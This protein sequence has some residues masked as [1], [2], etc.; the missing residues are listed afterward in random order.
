MPKTVKRPKM[1]ITGQRV[2]YRTA[3]LPQPIAWRFARCLNKN[4]LFSDVKHHWD[5][6]GCYVRYR[7]STPMR[8]EEMLSRLQ[9]ERVVRAQEQG[10]SWIVRPHPSLPNRY[11]VTTHVGDQKLEGNYITSETACS[12]PDGLRVRNI[13]LL[14]KHRVYIILMN[15]AQDSQCAS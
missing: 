12:C 15:S 1:V 14:C 4:P 13:G 5:G 7:P 11:N 3:Y 9:M 2:Y 6:K 8:R 10:P